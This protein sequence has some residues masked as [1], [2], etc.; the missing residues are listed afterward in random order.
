MD[1]RT[2]V[3][4]IISSYIHNSPKCSCS[5]FS[6]KIDIGVP[7]A[8][9]CYEDLELCPDKCVESRLWFFD[10]VIE[11]R[12]YYTETAQKWVSEYGDKRAELLEV[13]NFINARFFVSE[14]FITPKLYVT[15]ECDISYT[16]LLDYGL[17]DDEETAL[18]TLEFLTDY[19]PSFLNNVSPY[20]FSTVL[21]IYNSSTAINKLKNYLL[22]E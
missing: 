10:T 14:G 12:V 2:K 3:I 13:I 22:G 21:G 18:K 11:A 8:A 15:E 7:M 9:I 19:M 16:V 20:I 4:D 17:F 1:R 6:I 5:H